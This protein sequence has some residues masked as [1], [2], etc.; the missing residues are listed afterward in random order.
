MTASRARGRAIRPRNDVRGATVAGSRPED[1]VRSAQRYGRGSGCCGGQ[2]LASRRRDR[3]PQLGR[4]RSRR[5]DL[6]V[7]WI[8]RRQG[9]RVRDR[10]GGA[11]AVRARGRRAASAARRVVASR[12]GARRPTPG[13][14][15][16]QVRDFAVGRHGLN[17]STQR[18]LAVP[19]SSRPCAATAVPRL[20]LLD[21][22]EVVVVLVV[23]AV[24]RAVAVGVGVEPVACRGTWIVERRLLVDAPSSTA[25]PRQVAPTS[26]ATFVRK[27]PSSSRSPSFEAAVVA[28]ADACRAS[29]SA[30]AGVRRR[31]GTCRSCGT[32]CGSRCRRTGSGA[33]M[34][35]QPSP[36]LVSWLACRPSLYQMLVR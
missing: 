14:G 36:A 13:C 18:P 9:V 17:G 29:S 16:G 30:Y 3:S 5:R 21:V 34:P 24:D 19:T 28:A 12:N 7:G 20:D 15:R 2:R 35:R 23:E 11:E 25:A 1:C 8:G 32:R 22:E 4:A 26:P 31:P 33:T 6:R 10:V 27:S